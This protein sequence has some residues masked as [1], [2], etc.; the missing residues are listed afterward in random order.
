MAQ[1]HYD[2]EL[3]LTVFQGLEAQLQSQHDELA[4]LRK[5]KVELEAQLHRKDCELLCLEKETESLRRHAAAFMQAITSTSQVSSLSNVS[6][7]SN[8]T[9]G[10][11]NTPRQIVALKA[12]SDCA[13]LETTSKLEEQ[14]RSTH[15]YE[16][17]Q[18]LKIS[19]AVAKSDRLI[20]ELTVS[21]SACLSANTSLLT[22]TGSLQAIQNVCGLAEG[23]NISLQLKH[24]ELVFG[25]QHQLERA[26]N[27]EAAASTGQKALDALQK[28][29]T[30]LLSAIASETSLKRRRE[31]PGTSEPLSSTAHRES[32]VGAAATVYASGASNS[33]EIV[34]EHPRRA[35]SM[36]VGSGASRGI[37]SAKDRAVPLTIGL[38]EGSSSVSIG[39]VPTVGRGQANA[40][41]LGVRFA[42]H[43]G[44][45]DL[46]PLDDDSPISTLKKPRTRHVEK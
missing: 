20:S 37:P 21:N 22:L 4:C 19:A 36:N 13:Y 46:S 6:L 41:G 16:K 2:V 43:D 24:D 34:Q 14:L 29:H 27:A 25:L 28:K 12:E 38:R 31:Q 32:R 9:S 3:L 33:A 23:K 30:A 39:K 7:F 17:E 5:A 18:E 40:H 45:I 26:S 10:I 1:S 35:L 8:F 11:P 42:P 44:S 15:V